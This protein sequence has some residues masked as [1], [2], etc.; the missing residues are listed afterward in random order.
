MADKKKSI[1]ELEFEEPSTALKKSLSFVNKSNL[2]KPIEW[3][4]E[5]LEELDFPKDLTKVSLG[6]LG[7]LMSKWSSVMS[8]AEYIVAQADI[9]KTAKAN[10]FNLAK[11]KKYLKLR[12]NDNLTENERNTMK[13]MGD[14]AKIEA[15][16]EYEK[17]KYTLAKAM[18]SGY[19]NYYNALSRELSRRGDVPADPSNQRVNDASGHE[20]RE[21]DRQKK[22]TGSLFKAMNEP[23]P[24]ECKEGSRLVSKVDSQNFSK[25]E[26]VEIEEWKE[27]GAVVNGGLIDFETLDE[28]FEVHEEEDE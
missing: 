5:E 17:A 6:H 14:V 9:Q 21:I 10:Q 7:E 3:A 23:K 24:T 8:Y 11:N 19:K 12:Q 25:G 26:L 1:D 28:N 16:Y 13:S 15:E 2:P 4:A 22:K 27:D 18:L 20:D